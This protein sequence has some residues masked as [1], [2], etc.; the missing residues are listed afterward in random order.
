MHGDSEMGGASDKL[1]AGEISLV[2]K[3]IFYLR[4]LIEPPMRFL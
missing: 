1:F 2:S 3:V 4:I